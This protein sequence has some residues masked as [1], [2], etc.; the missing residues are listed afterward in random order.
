MDKGKNIQM[1]LT[2]EE[3]QRKIEQITLEIQEANE[4]W[5]RV[6][7]TTAIYKVATMTLDEDVASQ[8]KRKKDIEMETEDLREKIRLHERKDDHSEEKNKAFHSNMIDKLRK[9]GEKYPVYE[10][11]DKSGPNN[12]H[13][14]A[15][16]ENDDEEIIY[17]H[18][19]LGTLKLICVD[20]KLADHPY[21]TRSKGPTDFFPS[22]SSDKGKAVM[23]D[24]NEDV[25]LIDVVVAQR[26]IA[27]QNE[28]ILQLMMQQIAEMRV[29]MQRRH[30][31][32]P[33]GFAA[34]VADG[35][36]QSTSL[37]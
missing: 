14:E 6:D 18:P 1:E 10:Q 7:M 12:A 23:G 3:L 2:G 28:F 33:P 30:D 16:E 25:S 20:Q 31:L 32:P 5:L 37:C 26:T 19:F 13:P 27:D 34:N 24:V 17:K 15:T 29:E 22:Q 36:I 11:G 9:M 4:K 8:M 35:G 21:F